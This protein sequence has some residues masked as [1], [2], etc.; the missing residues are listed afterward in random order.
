MRSP[1]PAPVIITEYAP[2]SSGQGIMP[3]EVDDAVVVDDALVV[4]EVPVVDD[5]LVDEAVVVPVPVD[6]GLPDDVEVVVPVL[7]PPPVPPVPFPLLQA[8]EVTTRAAADTAKR[9]D[10]FI[11]ARDYQQ[12]SLHCIGARSARSICAGPSSGRAAPNRQ[13]VG[14]AHE[15]ARPSNRRAPSLRSSSID[16]ERERSNLRPLRQSLHAAHKG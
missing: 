8:C 5:A 6:V 4:D 14:R 3:L 11:G 16:R 7:A 13:I 10:D 1:Q 2:S 15:R 12:S 9:S